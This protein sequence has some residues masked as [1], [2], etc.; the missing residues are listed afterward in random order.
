MYDIKIDFSLSKTKKLIRELRSVEYRICGIISVLILMEK[1]FTP[2][3][4]V[5]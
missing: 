4:C 3:A 2:E 5:H 1:K